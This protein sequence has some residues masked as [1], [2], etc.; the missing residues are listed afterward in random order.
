MEIYTIALRLNSSF[1]FLK[2]MNWYLKKM[3]NLLFY[4]NFNKVRKI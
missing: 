1:L 2:D 3:M 4:G